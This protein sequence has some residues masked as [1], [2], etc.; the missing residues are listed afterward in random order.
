MAEDI[1]QAR[2]ELERERLA[3]ELELKRAEIAL[4]RD[5][6]D[7]THAQQRRAGVAFSP[8]ATGI[9]AALVGLVGT[10][11]GAYMQG[12][13]QLNIER[14]KFESNLILKAIETGNREEAKN[15]LLFLVHAGFIE[16]T[17]GKIA[18]LAQNPSAIPVLPF[19]GNIDVETMRMKR[20]LD[21]REQTLDIRRKRADEKASLEERLPRLP[22]EERAAAHE[23]LRKL[24]ADIKDL[25][26]TV[27]ELD[28][29]VRAAQERRNRQAKDIID[30]IGR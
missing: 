9:I 20:A 18:A 4:R 15:N 21:R 2:L 17:G 7:A 6:L 1:E 8:L 27:R 26:R 16:D 30:S 29:Q 25:D 24:E 19:S 23:R 14:L 28:D 12:R 11:V 3:G 5:E 22:V 13:S 10:G